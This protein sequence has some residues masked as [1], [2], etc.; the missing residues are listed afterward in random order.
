MKV[1]VMLKQRMGAN[2]QGRVATRQRLQ[3]LLSRLAFGST[4]EQ[5][6]G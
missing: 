5:A 6:T 4:A 3:D 2:D 1:Y